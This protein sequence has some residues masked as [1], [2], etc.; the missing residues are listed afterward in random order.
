MRNIVEKNT[1]A[2]LTDLKERMAFLLIIPKK[3]NYRKY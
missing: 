3:R 1:K 2:C